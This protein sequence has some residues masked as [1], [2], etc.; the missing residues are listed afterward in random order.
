MTRCWVVK[1]TGKRVD[2]PDEDFSSYWR[3]SFPTPEEAQKAIDDFGGD[4]N[5][6]Q[7]TVVEALHNGDPMAWWV[8]FE[9]VANA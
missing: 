6:R 8:E 2:R 4:A 5:G 3:Q 7:H 1:S 9:M